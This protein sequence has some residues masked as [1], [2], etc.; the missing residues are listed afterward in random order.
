MVKNDVIKI[1]IAGIGN[2][3][4]GLLQGINYLNIFEDKKKKLGK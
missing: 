2:I 1:A 3:A 4:S